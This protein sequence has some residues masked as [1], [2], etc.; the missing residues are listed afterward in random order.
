MLS[1]D[2]FLIQRAI[3]IFLLTIAQ[4][5]FWQKRAEDMYEKIIYIFTTLSVC[6]YSGLGIS[7]SNV[8]LY[9]IGIYFAF[10]VLLNGAIYFVF[11]LQFVNGLKLVQGK[12]IINRDYDVL[13]GQRIV[14]I[15]TILFYAT[16][17]MH[18]LYPT[19]RIN[20]LWNPPAPS[21]EMIYA[22]HAAASNTAILSFC[23]TLNIFARPFF[24]CYLQQ[25]LK[26][27]KRVKFVLM[28]L[29]WIYLVYLQYG[30]IGR[31]Q[32]V[33]FVL[34]IF[35]ALYFMK[36]GEFVFP[37][38][39]VL[40][41]L[42]VGIIS[43][44]LLLIYQYV[45]VGAS[46]EGDSLAEAFSELIESE[47][48]YPQYYAAIETF[49][50]E[51]SIVTFLLWIVCL[52]IPSAI[53]PWKPIV[54]ITHSFTE[55]ISGLVYGA[56]DYYSSLLPS[57]L[58]EGMMVWGIEFSWIHALVIGVVIGFYLRWLHKYKSLSLLAVYQMLLLFTLGRGGA[59]SLMGSFI[60]G[61]IV[62]LL[63]YCFS[64]KNYMPDDINEYNES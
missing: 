7:Y 21:T 58:G 41:L 57:V 38:K 55:H 59:S 1:I 6:I 54:T 27:G 10:I 34:F 64:D 2:D 22:K 40:L 15:F 16:L 53:F 18:L 39:Y 5:R 49:A 20:V 32:I 3:V 63:F 28:V 13:I 26:Y 23:D 11:H 19:V 45:R 24:L 50:G 37:K 47:I 9:F 43:I 56:Q 60:N 12:K 48:S 29:M 30:Y 35:F 8:S 31:Y 17:V 42:V 44:P 36:N 61:A 25:Q 4:L 33:I 51:S 14:I 52:P 62:I 46:Y